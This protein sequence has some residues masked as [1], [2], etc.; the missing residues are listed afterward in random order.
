LKPGDFDKAQDTV[1]TSLAKWNS[2][3]TIA[4]DP[5]VESAEAMG[6]KVGRNLAIRVIIQ[7]QQQVLKHLYD[8]FQIL[9][10]QADKL[11]REMTKKDMEK[12]KRHGHIS[13]YYM[14][15][16]QRRFASQAKYS[17]IAESRKEAVRQEEKEKVVKASAGMDSPNNKITIEIEAYKA[18]E[19]KGG[20]V[21]GSGGGARGGFDFN[22]EFKISD[23]LISKSAFDARGFDVDSTV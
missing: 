7:G 15:L 18:V 5:S 21:F 10:E 9:D 2:V 11:V 3:Y 22:V 8:Y 12:S 20:I 13:W 14:Q 19:N 6:E 4:Q 17:I 1:L 23:A 16:M